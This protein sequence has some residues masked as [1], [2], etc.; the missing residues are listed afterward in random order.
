[1]WAPSLY[2]LI[3]YYITYILLLFF[4]AKESNKNNERKKKIIRLKKIPSAQRVIIVCYNS[5]YV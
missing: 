2:I 5:L 1:M 4:I 3:K